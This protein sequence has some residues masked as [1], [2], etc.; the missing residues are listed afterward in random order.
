MRP[1]DHREIGILGTVLTTDTLYA[2]LICDG[3][4]VDPALVNLWWRA[5]GGEKAI[6]ITD[7]M[8][9]AGMP[10]GQYMLGEFP[11][12]V[13]NGKATANG[14][15]AG[16]VLTLDLALRNFMAFTCAPLREALPLLT[17]NPAAMTGFSADCGAIRVGHRADLV[18]LG[19]DGALLASVIG[20]S[21][22]G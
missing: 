11:V 15:L 8:S 10:D 13:A 22:Q 9:A 1:L 21:L 4:H 5:K 6:L 18:A 3:I 7:A 20:G 17:R 12:Q 14:V 19:A 2:E 16:S